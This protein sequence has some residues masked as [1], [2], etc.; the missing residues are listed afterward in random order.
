MKNDEEQVRRGFGIMSANGELL[1]VK[2]ESNHGS[3]HCGEN[4]YTFT[5]APHE[6]EYWAETLD[7][8][9]I[10][11]VF[12]TPWYN[13]SE[14]RPSHDDGDLLKGATIV[15]IEE[16]VR[17][18]YTPIEDDLPIVLGQNLRHSVT[19]EGRSAWIVRDS[20]NLQVGDRA[21]ACQY[22]GIKTVQC[23]EPIPN[24]W[25]RQFSNCVLIY[26]V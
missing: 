10:A 21:I 3:V 13:S 2:S 15:A 11:V 17:R 8:S 19:R 18:N 5:L 23:I 26:H 16:V 22:T 6:P 14:T 24:C 25:Q 20:V 1:R 7:E 9:T 4:R 12:D